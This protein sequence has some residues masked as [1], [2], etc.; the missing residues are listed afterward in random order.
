MES[1]NTQFTTVFSS[2]FVISLTGIFT[3]NSLMTIMFK[4]LVYR[5]IYKK[6]PLSENPINV[7]ILVNETES[8][9]GTF[10]GYGQMIAILSE[11]RFNF[12]ALCH[13]DSI[14]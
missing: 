5:L 9:L 3:F 1:N 13:I 4:V 7:L 14:N 2:S 12:V 6:G 11:N 10:I 8:M